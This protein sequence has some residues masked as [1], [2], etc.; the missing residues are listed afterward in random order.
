MKSRHW[1]YAVRKGAPGGA[2]LFCVLAIA[3]T[4]QAQQQ[5][6]A[7]PPVYSVTPPAMQDYEAS[8]P[9]APQVE[10]LAAS[11]GDEPRWLQWGPVTLHP[12]LLYRFLYGNGIESAPGQPQTT[13]IQ[14]FSP[15][16]LF[17]IG[18]H[19]TLDY[20]PLFSYYSSS[21]FQNTVDESVALTWGT[22]YQD[23]VLGFSQSYRASSAPLIQT[24]VQTDT[25]T[26]STS[27][28]ASYRFSSKMSAD[29]SISQNFL[30]AQ[31]FTSTRSWSTMD[32][33][34]YEPEDR[35]DVGVGAGYEYDDVTP[36]P[37]AMDEVIQGRIRWRATG[38]TS[39]TVHAGLE[40]QQYLGG[41]ANSLITPVFGASIQYQ[42]VETTTLSLTADRSVTPSLFQGQ[43]TESTSVG[44]SLSQRL[45]KR[46]NLSLGAGYGTSSYL[47]TT[48]SPTVGTGRVD[49]FYSFNVR[50]G[51]TFFERGTAAVFY[52]YS[53]N[54]STQPGFAFSS[55]QVGVE[56]GYRY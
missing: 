46:L 14:Q 36:G 45:L 11:V 25:E 44:I 54:P 18:S 2:A 20:T 4:M 56:L 7:P 6:L 50:L 38:K 27:A 49:N 22:S 42:P 39:F 26:Y 47:A 53:D 51:T 21:S 10:S 28:S 30:F 35:W 33:L 40:D 24:G 8:Q 5:V 43:V 55:S 29:M 52:Q 1:N 23:W 12:H 19:W 37:N 32:W 34:N 17:A 9:G 13:A 48:N 41:G 3:R 31:Q 15:G 16:V